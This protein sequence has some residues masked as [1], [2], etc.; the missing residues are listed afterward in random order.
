MLKS[1]GLKPKN[2][3]NRLDGRK[4]TEQESATSP[5][6]G[7]GETQLLENRASGA[8]GTAWEADAVLPAS[9]KEGRSE[10]RG[11]LEGSTAGTSQ[12]W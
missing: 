8:C 3:H 1:A 6:P 11:T 5:T 9:R 10:Q 2:R 12:S 4:M 7:H